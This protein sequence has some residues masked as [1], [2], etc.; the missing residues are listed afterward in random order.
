MIS[1]R[2]NGFPGDPKMSNLRLT[3]AGTGAVWARRVSEWG[4]GPRSISYPFKNTKRSP[5]RGRSLSP[6]LKIFFPLEMSKLLFLKRGKK[7][8]FTKM[9][10]TCS[11]KVGIQ[12]FFY[13]K[14]ANFKLYNSVEEVEIKSACY[15]GDQTG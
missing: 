12:N 14:L 5:K 1:R 3:L 6:C 4:Q 8:V 7:A 11:Y 13:G 2:S 9:S 15:R 10:I